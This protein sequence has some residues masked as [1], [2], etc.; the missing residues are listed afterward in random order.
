MSRDHRKCTTCELSKL[1]LL[2]EAD[3]PNKCLSC[4]LLY[5]RHEV[6]DLR[7]RLETKPTPKPKNWWGDPAIA[8]LIEVLVYE[9]GTIRGASERSG[10]T[11]SACRTKA[12]EL[13]LRR[14]YLPLNDGMTHTE[15]E[16]AKVYHCLYVRQLSSYMTAA[17]LGYKSRDVVIGIND[18]HIRHQKEYWH[19]R[20]EP[21]ADF[22]WPSRTTKPRVAK[23][24]KSHPWRV[25][26]LA[27]DGR[28]KNAD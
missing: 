4:R 25:P 1:L 8:A 9:R 12:R 21:P 26:H 22:P 18:R 17:T 14:E 27:M 6:L 16:I 13:R 15:E 2:F 11:L 20:W 5:S 7:R 24:R 19:G 3:E 10:K 28:K 23:P